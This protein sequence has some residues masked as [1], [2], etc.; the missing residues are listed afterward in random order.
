M[1]CHK[2]HDVTIVQS[3]V[4]ISWQ[5]STGSNYDY[6]FCYCPLVGILFEVLRNV[7]KRKSNDCVM[8]QSILHQL[9]KP[10]LHTWLKVICFSFND[11]FKLWSISFQGYHNGFVYQLGYILLSIT[12]FII[13][14]N[15]LKTNIY[16]SINQSLSHSCMKTHFETFDY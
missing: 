11:T 8:S 3:D 15:H 14:L 7:S 2:W 13:Q 10:Q 5:L 12:I 4:T 9:S 6:H 16:L 1:F